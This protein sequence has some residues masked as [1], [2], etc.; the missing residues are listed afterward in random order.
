MAVIE[1][2]DERYSSMPDNHQ[3]LIARR[4]LDPGVATRDFLPWPGDEQSI[5]TYRDMDLE[6]IDLDSVA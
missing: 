2:I 1:T 5:S 3:I 6:Q 4:S